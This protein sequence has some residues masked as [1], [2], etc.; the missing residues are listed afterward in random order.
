[1]HHGMACARDAIYAAIMSGDVCR[2]GQYNSDNA[3]NCLGLHWVVLVLQCKGNSEMTISRFKY[4]YEIS[5]PVTQSVQR[6]VTHDLKNSL[7]Q[8]GLLFMI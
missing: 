3:F 5:I 4:K 1:M 7:R 6:S 2:M 8:G